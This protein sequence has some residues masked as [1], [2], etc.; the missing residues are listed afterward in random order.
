MKDASKKATQHENK[1]DTFLFFE[2]TFFVKMNFY[3]FPVQ[4]NHG[5]YFER[6]GFLLESEKKNQKQTNPTHTHLFFF[7]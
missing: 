7:V 1:D 6:V 5:L 2:L 4:G 3:Q